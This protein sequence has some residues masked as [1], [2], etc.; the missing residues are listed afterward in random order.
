MPTGTPS[1]DNFTKNNL[2][3]LTVS[4]DSAS[5]LTSVDWANPTLEQLDAWGTMDALD[6]FGTLEQ[7]ADLDVIHCSGSAPIAFTAT[8]AIQ[9]AIEVAG[10]AN[11]AVTV[12]SD[13]N[14]IRTMSASITGAFG[15]TA[16][17]T[18]LRQMSGTAS[19]AVTSA[20]DYNRLISVVGTASAVVTST[21]S[22][23]ILYL[24]QGTA[25][26]EFTATG[27]TTGVFVEAGTTQAQIS[28]T[29]VSY[30]HLTLPTIL[31]V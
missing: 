27:A 20:A 18:P 10:T 8:A 9:F 1:L 3:T 2:D 24:A 12:A 16:T 29:A 11:I 23:N 21:A 31:R 5:F 26:A 19:I 15:F 4:L 6:G 7:L 22:S 30:T 17:I 28:V 14:R 25:T 13:A